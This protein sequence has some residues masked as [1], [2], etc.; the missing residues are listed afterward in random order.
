MELD[1]ATCLTDRP[2]QGWLLKKK[3]CGASRASR[4]FK[5]TNRRYFTLDFPGL[6]LY[7]ANSESNKLISMPIHMQN[8]TKVELFS[9]SAA[10]N[11]E[12]ANGS[13]AI[14]QNR[15]TQKS[16]VTVGEA[17]TDAALDTKPDTHSFLGPLQEGDSGPSKEARPK[18][19]RQMLTSWVPM[20]KLGGR[21]AEQTEHGFVVHYTYEGEAR[22][23]ELICSSKAEAT[24]WTVA[25]SA[26]MRLAGREKA[27]S[28]SLDLCVEDLSTDNDSEHSSQPSLL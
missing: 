1:T 7:Y 6:T 13:D 19:P 17:E 9:A 16:L 21:K 5:K 23:M 22:N 25:L 14:Q 20:P 3:G 10:C 11:R 4:L 18:T 8:I 15:E 2:F 28:R 24:Q 12:G 26:A 27:R